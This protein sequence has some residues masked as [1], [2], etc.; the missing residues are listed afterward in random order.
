MR[1]LAFIIA[2]L[3]SAP[4]FA[5]PRAIL[6][7]IDGLRWQEAFHGADAALAP[8]HPSPGDP[9]ALMPFLQTFAREGALIGDRNA[10]SCMRVENKY[11]FSYPGYTEMLAGRPNPRIRR[12]GK[13]WNKEV[14]ALEWLN[15]RDDFRGRVRVFA[16]WAKVPFI[17]NTRRSNIPVIVAPQELERRDPPTMAAADAIFT[18]P[19]RVAWIDLGD[20]D[21]RAHAGDY[22]GVLDA[23]QKA[24][25][26][27]AAL[28]ARIEAHPDFAGQTTLIVTV[29]HGRGGNE[30]DKWKGHGSGWY[31]GM[32]VPGVGWPGS[33]ATWVA[34]R[35]PGIAPGSDG[36][37]TMDACATTAQVAA[38]L[39]R[40][41]GM[42]PT[43]YRADVREALDVLRPQ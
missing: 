42:A 14:T 7:T 28:W 2:L 18:E 39:L 22:A 23:A 5:E 13:I 38:T 11:W 37:Y 41:V 4:A 25:A 3:F 30:D 43:D 8:D 34:A 29:D 9:Q 12:N 21:T 15:G 24:D 16:E 17:V 20:T 40:S 36:G 19:T 1:V 32:R 10:G 33:D 31:R 27:L 26:F 6:V 35:G